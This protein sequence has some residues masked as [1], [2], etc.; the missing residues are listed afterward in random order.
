MKRTAT[1]I[2]KKENG[3]LIVDDADHEESTPEV[4]Q[5]IPPWVLVLKKE[6]IIGTINYNVFLG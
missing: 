4:V 6:R 3:Y 2:L 1:S 5:S